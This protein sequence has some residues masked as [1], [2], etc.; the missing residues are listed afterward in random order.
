MIAYLISVDNVK[1]LGLVHENANDKL[2]SVA[3]RRVQDLKIQEALG[4][5]LY[6]ELIN[7]VNNNNV[8]GDYLSL[9]RDYVAPCLSAY[10]DAYVSIFIQNKITNKMENGEENVDF[11]DKLEKH[12]MFYRQ[13]LIDYLE[14]ANFPEYKKTCSENKSGYSFNWI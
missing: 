3:I 1:K 2:I 14:G 6:N 8:T 13:R 7:R 5:D 12:G 11:T 9:L 10:V 4:S